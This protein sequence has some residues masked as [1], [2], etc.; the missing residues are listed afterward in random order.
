MGNNSSTSSLNRMR[1]FCALFICLLVFSIAGEESDEAYVV[2]LVFIQKEGD[3][4]SC[5]NTR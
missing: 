3:T 2:L 4:K 5:V 1:F